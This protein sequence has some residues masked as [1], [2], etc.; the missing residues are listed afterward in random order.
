MTNRTT[1][2]TWPIAEPAEQKGQPLQ[3]VGRVAIVVAPV[4][5]VEPVADDLADPILDE[6]NVVARL[7][8]A[9]RALLALPSSGLRPAGYRSMMPDVLRVIWEAGLTAENVVRAAPPSPSAIDRMD[10]VYAWLGYVDDPTR[11]RIVLLRSLVNP[12]TGRH[13]YAWR[14]IARLFNLD[15]KTV[16]AWHRDA[17]WTIVAG[18]SRKKST[19]CPISLPK[20]PKI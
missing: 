17:V 1:E 2:V 13:L 5:P 19:P 15:H 14:R 18:L 4:Q 3:I 20:F 8:D 16:Q 7:E 11:R 10:R 12:M 6:T 9:G